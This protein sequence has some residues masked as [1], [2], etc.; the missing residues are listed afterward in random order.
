[1][2]D[3]QTPETLNW[4]QACIVLGCSKAHFYRLIDAGKIATVSPRRINGVRVRMED[5]LAFLDERERN[6]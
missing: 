6:L 1:M 4:R 2:I 3:K 5:C